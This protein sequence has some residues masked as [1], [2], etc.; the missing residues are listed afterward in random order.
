MA[1]TIAMVQDIGNEIARKQ[2]NIDANCL[3][4]IRRLWIGIEIGLQILMSHSAENVLFQSRW[5]VN[6]VKIVLPNKRII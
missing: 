5:R 4:P 1:E 2:R 3:L 6:T